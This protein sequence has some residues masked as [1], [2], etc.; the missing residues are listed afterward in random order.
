M[1]AEAIRTLYDYHF[2]LNR[3]VWDECIMTLSEGQY[4]QDSDYSLGAIRSHILHMISVDAR[5]FARLQSQPLPNFTAEMYPTRDSARALW[6]QVEGEMR[7]YLDRLT[8]EQASGT[9]EYDMPHRGGLKHDPVWLVLVH[10]MTH[11]VDHRAQLL[12][13]LHDLD[14]PTLEQ[15]LIIHHWKKS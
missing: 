15:D 14:A 5:W 7:A 1:N 10:V 11:S 8:D 9:V 13:L 3:R 6:D 2:T 4:T 12:A